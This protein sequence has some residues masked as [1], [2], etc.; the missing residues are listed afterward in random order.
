M[1]KTLLLLLILWLGVTEIQ[2][3]IDTYSIGAS[4]IELIQNGDYI[5]VSFTL[6]VGRRATKSNYNLVVNPVIRNGNSGVQLPSVIVR[7]KRARIFSQRHELATG[8]RYY[9]QE[10]RYMAPGESIA[11]QATVP[12]ESWMT[13]AQLIL[14]GIS[15]GC[16]SSTETPIG[17]IADNILYALPQTE[18]RVVE[19]PVEIQGAST[20]DQLAVQ[21]AFVAPIS[22][23]EKARETPSGMFDYNMPLS[24]GK[25]LTDVRQSEVERFIN[26]TR[27][28]SI[29]IYFR[30]GVRTIDRNFNQN[31]KLLVELISAVRALVASGDSRVAR[32]VIAGFASPEGTLALND[33]LAWDRAV[34]VKEFLTAN[35]SL[36]PEIVHIYNGSVDWTGLREL[37]AKSDIYQKYRIIDIIDHTPVWDSSRGVGRHSELMRLDGGEPYRYMLREFFPKLRQAAYIKVY[38]E[39]R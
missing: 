26:E 8:Q 29:S 20:G 13:G 15:V 22:D 16:C 18:I 36:P 27:E 25:G 19:V 24:L 21:Y 34:A 4:D 28:G 2:A 33:R 38:Y 5:T 37:V 7:G 11:Y 14:E 30:Q 12:Y 1:K 10:P 6:S 39:N 17:L 35:S 3:Q 9:Q 23:F 32:V 31:N